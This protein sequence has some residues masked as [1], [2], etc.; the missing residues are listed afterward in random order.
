MKEVVRK[1][2]VPS[3]R[4]KMG[5]P[6]GTRLI[7]RKGRAGSAMTSHVVQVRCDNRGP[8][9]RMREHARHRP[10]P[11]VPEVGPGGTNCAVKLLTQE[12]ETSLV[13]R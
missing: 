4:G 12:A 2:R 13:L 6:L 8:V 7:R 10:N 11:L 1:Y 3:G 9:R 5:A